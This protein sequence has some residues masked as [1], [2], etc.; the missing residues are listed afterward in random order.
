M[1]PFRGKVHGRHDDIVD[2]LYKHW[3]LATTR[4]LEYLMQHLKCFLQYVRRTHVDLGNY[5]ED[6]N[7]EGKSQPK[8]LLCHSHN[9]SVC[10]NLNKANN[11]LGHFSF[12]LNY[13][14]LNF[15]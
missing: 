10:S 14:K 13:L 11:K 4:R 8:V 1:L 12:H 15:S 9:T 7:A 2:G 3:H 6:W 5:N